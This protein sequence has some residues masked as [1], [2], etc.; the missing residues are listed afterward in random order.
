MRMVFD[1]IPPRSGLVGLVSSPLVISSISSAAHYNSMAKRPYGEGGVTVGA[2][3]VTAA[4]GAV[5]LPGV[6]GG[7]GIGQGVGGA[8]GII[9][10]A[11]GG[12][13][14]G[15]AIQGGDWTP[16]NLGNDG[17]PLPTGEWVVGVG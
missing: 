10:L 9:S 13:K 8:L 17:L 16:V 11:G 12:P 14:G 7:T 3:G 5:S 6:S 2:V 1:N 15:E 4:N